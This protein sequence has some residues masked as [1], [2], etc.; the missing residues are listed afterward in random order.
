[1]IINGEEHNDLCVGIDL[2]TTNSVLATINVRPNKNIVSRVVDLPRA[3]DM[4]TGVSGG[5]KFQSKKMPTLP[6]CVY[7]NEE[8]GYAPLVG[9]FAKHRY[10]LRPALVAKSIK[11]QMGQPEASGLAE[12]V[13]DNTPAKVSSRILAH[14]L[15]N[16]G[17]IYHTEIHDAVIT[18]PANFD[19]AMCQATRQAAELAGIVVRNRDGSE[20]P[21][22][23]SEPNA[24]IYDFINQA[25]NGEIS[26]HILDLSEKKN[27]LV[28]DLG[29]GTLDIT[30][31]EIVQ[32]SDYKDAL[33]VN[34]VATNR[35]TLL[36]GDDFDAK[37]AEAM[38]ARYLQQ[39]R[40]HPHVVEKIKR[41]ENAV[42]SQMLAYAE[43]M[44]LEISA[45]HSD[46]FAVD[47]DDDW[48]LDDDSYPVGGT[49]SVTGYAYD[50]SFS[51]QEI[52]E[53]FDGFMGRGLRYDD[54]RHIDSIAETRNIIYPVLDVLAK[55]AQKLGDNALKVDAVIMNGGMSRFYMVVDRVREF[56][57]LEPIVALDPDQAVARGAAVYHY[58]L[59]QYEGM[60]D[61]M[62]KLGISTA[63]QYE[64]IEDIRHQTAEAIGRNKDIVDKAPM[65]PDI[66]FGKTVLNDSIY[67]GLKN[68]ERLEIVA[69]GTE[70]PYTSEWLTGFRLSKGINHFE[71]PILVRN[72]DNT[73]RTMAS[74]CLEFSRVYPEGAYIIFN[75][76]VNADKVIEMHAWT[77]EDEA[78]LKKL[79]EGRTSIVMG[80]YEAPVH[81]MVKV[82]S[83]VPA[84]K[85]RAPATSPK[86]SPVPNG[87]RV[88]A[89]ECFRS[90]RTYCSRFSAGSSG[91][92]K[93]IKTIFHDLV[94]ASNRQEV[95][96]AL[97]KQYNSMGHGNH[98]YNTRLYIMGRRLSASMGSEQ[99]RKL[100]LA[101]MAELEN[102]LEFGAY[103]SSGSSYGPKVNAVVQAIFTLS[104]CASHEQLMRLTRLHSN[105]RFREALMYTH[106]RTKTCVDWIYQKFL[107]DVEE[108][109]FRPN[110]HLQQSAYSVG[111][112]FYN[113]GR[114]G[115]G[116]ISK[117]K[118]I[119][120]LC[121]TIYSKKLT[122]VAASGVALAI[123]WICDQ[124]Y[125]NDILA[126]SLARARKAMEDFESLYAFDVCYASQKLRMLTL[127]MLG[128][129][130]LSED[131]ERFLLEK[132]E[133]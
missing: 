24:V 132:L 52:E 3:V 130:E 58:Y 46:E 25:R 88:N 11:S 80:R 92:A 23:L 65:R 43:E 71:I 22:L 69:T 97:M 68:G 59:H 109:R 49:I 81:R 104:V 79:E 123:G 133:K 106:A 6:S 103:F 96:A 125:A 31:H 48:S 118:V 28:F 19:S 36:G 4:F 111:V 41:E 45:K 30:L 95:V 44:K 90:M 51:E 116:Q 14:M 114:V 127:K 89:D 131:E 93:S 56:F 87:P 33:R 110:N 50:D 37:L 5:H 82:N 53:I 94:T 70:L 129:I 83:S 2:G 99:K 60:K 42:M 73:Y 108:N 86:L 74:G 113:D 13:P 78:G 122:S 40:N 35:Y 76:S 57:G 63:E 126:S 17:K 29:G 18:V 84:E 119:S 66:E 27:V 77:C 124:R 91:V 32:R 98:E 75:V 34:E 105:S 100:S 121:D 115:D 20:R 112:A 128:G 117:D 26:S 7:Y 120:V 85:L 12:E 62:I 15:K 16:A 8:E 67:M 101:C 38:Y 72:I 64:N 10:A 1:M 102:E 39:Y 61:D 21:V 54:Y 9:D 55:A 47:D 107:E